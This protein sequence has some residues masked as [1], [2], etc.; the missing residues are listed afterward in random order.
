MN[1]VTGALGGSGNATGALNGVVGTVTGALGNAGGSSK[2]L[3]PRPVSQT[4]DGRIS[5]YFATSAETGVE[6]TVRG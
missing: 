3:A 5:V 2:R 6:G 1:T 4:L